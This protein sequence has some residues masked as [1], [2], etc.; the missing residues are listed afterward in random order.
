MHISMHSLGDA[1]YFS[2]ADGNQ[3]MLILT[4][5]REQVKATA[6]SQVLRCAGQCC[7]VG[8]GR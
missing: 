5:I 7:R 1:D 3:L 4:H 8:D 6:Q 2:L